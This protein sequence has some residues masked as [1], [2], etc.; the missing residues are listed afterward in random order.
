MK[1][2]VTTAL[3][4]VALALSVPVAGAEPDSYQ[5]QLKTA[6]SSD[7]VSRY[8]DRTYAGS[9][10]DAVD[11]AVANRQSSVPQDAFDRAPIADRPVSTL[12]VASGANTDA[13]DGLAGLGLVAALTLAMALGAAGAAVLTP[14]G[15]RMPAHR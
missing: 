15:R 7:V 11:H 5:P 9:V 4:L 3:A 6:D 2:L 8:L 1:A 10:P 13:S 14:L 12:P